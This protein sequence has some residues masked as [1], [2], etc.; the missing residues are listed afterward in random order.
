MPPANPG[1]LLAIP[2]TGAYH[3]SMASNYNRYPRPAV[4][5]A[6]AG[7]ADVVVERETYANLVARDRIPARLAL[8]GAREIRPHLPAAGNPG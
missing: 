3:Y 8:A 1:D 4:V 7:L 6:K 2:T 5:F